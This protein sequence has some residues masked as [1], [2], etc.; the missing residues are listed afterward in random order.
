MMGGLRLWTAMKINEFGT[1]TSTGSV[2]RRP[3]VGQASGNF[4]HFL[5]AASVDDAAP[6]APLSDIAAA[7]P[8]SNI[9]ALQEIS[10]EESRRRKLKHQAHTML[11][12]L[13]KLRHQLL[14]GAVPA[15]MLSELAQRIETQ[16]QM[17]SDPGLQSL[18]ADIELRLAVELAKL[19]KAKSGNGLS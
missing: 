11:D 8:L 12:T 10:D 2:K 15:S 7:S 1:I 9:L 16:K 18:I 6:A 3:G 19:E 17:V 5:D 4:A 14:I 13:E